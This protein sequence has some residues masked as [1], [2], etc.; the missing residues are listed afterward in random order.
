MNMRAWLFFCVAVVTGCG[1][2]AFT[3]PRELGGVTV[4]PEVLNR[5]RDAYLVYCRACHGEKG[6][7][8]GPAGIGSR[9]P[10]RDFTQ[11]LFKFAAVPTGQLP[12]DED[13][14]RVVRKGLSG[15]TMLAWDVPGEDL[16]AIVQYLKT[17]SP[18]WSTDQPGERILP[19]PDP[20][21]GNA[22]GARARG[23]KMYHAVEC[24]ACHPAYATRQN[25]YDWLREV[26]GSA[27]RDFRDRMYSSLLKETQYGV[28]VQPPDFL[29][30]DIRAGTSPADLYRTIAS[31]IGGT[32]MPQWR[33]SLDEKDIWAMVHYVHDLIQKRD[34]PD[35][36][37]L[38]AV[39]DAP[40]PP[41]K[42]PQAPAPA[43][44]GGTP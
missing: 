29:R 27:S 5:G 34:T 7:G 21:Q 40:Q 10:A 19:S 9:P 2:P 12:N 1:E 18:R 14:I 17:F 38:R 43:A 44:D 15:T 37:A 3:K 25:V 33:G 30:S 35:A 41:L 32:A 11:G 28:S 39:L 13:L 16:F 31:G 23:E 20:W 26:R 42:I 6:D 22:A 4:Q 24:W 8:Q 36:R